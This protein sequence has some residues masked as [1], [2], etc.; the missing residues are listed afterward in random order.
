MAGRPACYERKFG[1]KTIGS[2]EATRTIAR[3]TE[4]W[5]HRP[6]PWVA[7]IRGLARSREELATAYRLDDKTRDIPRFFIDLHV[8][9]KG[10]WHHSPSLREPYRPGWS[11]GSQ[12]LRSPRGSSVRKA[13][14][15]R[16]TLKPAAPLIQ[17]VGGLAP[18]TVQYADTPTTCNYLRYKWAVIRR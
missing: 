7:L 12:W 16:F 9:T 11:C 13:R 18:S 5:F 1:P 15:S 2:N 14:S 3:M 10:T 6:L 8:S 4:I 17:R